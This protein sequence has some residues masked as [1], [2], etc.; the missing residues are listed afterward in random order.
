MLRF[1]RPLSTASSMIL[2]PSTRS[3]KLT[4]GL[5]SRF[6]TLPLVSERLDITKAI[7][8]TFKLP[9]EDSAAVRLYSSDDYD[10]AIV[11]DD[12][13]TV[14]TQVFARSSKIRYVDFCGEVFEVVCS[15]VLRTYFDFRTHLRRKLDITDV[16]SNH[17]A[18][19]RM[20]PDGA[21]HQE[22]SK[23]LPDI[24]EDSAAGFSYKYPILLRRTD[25]IKVKLGSS[26]L[27][28]STADC[29]TYKDVAKAIQKAALPVVIPPS[30]LALWYPGS[31]LI[32]L[33][34]A[35][36]AYSLG[37]E[38]KVLHA[39]RTDLI[40]V[41]I[42]GVDYTVSIAGCKTYLDV[43]EVI[44]KLRLPTATR[45]DQLELYY[46]SSTPLDLASRIPTYSIGDEKRVLNATMMVKRVIIVDY[47]A[48]QTHTEIRFTSDAE[49]R[50]FSSGL[51]EIR[52]GEEDTDS[53]PIRSLHLLKNGATYEHLF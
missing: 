13:L 32:T 4:L 2:Q 21:V 52:D 36:P 40:S 27:T 51:I 6:I 1:T 42:N 10:A 12:E 46:G 25:L 22:L 31:K 33:D 41:G 39:V 15:S 24:D 14:L 3:L 48:K 35:I 18:L 16:P 28:V 19:F 23:A 44:R 49:I 47:G 5:H 37:D 11:S 50:A 38:K 29:A 30:T 9:V 26:T 34:S 20:T 8:K 17:F 45:A 7:Q 53:A 43:A